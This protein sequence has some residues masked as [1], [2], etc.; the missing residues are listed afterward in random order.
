MQGAQNYYTEVLQ[1]KGYTVNVTTYQ[2]GDLY[3]CHVDNRD[4]GATIARAQGNDP[5]DVKRF[6]LEKAASRL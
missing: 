5:D 4:P 6:A 2:I 1:I 3:Y